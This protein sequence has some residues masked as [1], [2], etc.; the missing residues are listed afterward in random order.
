MVSHLESV[1]MS[2]GYKSYFICIYVSLVLHEIP[3]SRPYIT[4]NEFKSNNNPLVGGKYSD[5]VENYWI[6]DV[7]QDYIDVR[8]KTLER[9]EFQ[10]SKFKLTGGKQ[11]KIETQEVVNIGQS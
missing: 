2:V 4:F 1:Y 5:Y 10:P 6:G 9:K 11:R 8:E 7:P 3:T